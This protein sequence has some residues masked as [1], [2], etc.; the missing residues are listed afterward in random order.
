MLHVEH[1]ML[2]TYPDQAKS[3]GKIVRNP[4]ISALKR[5]S[6]Q[7][8]ASVDDI[9]YS[10]PTRGKI[11]RP[12]AQLEESVARYIFKLDTAD[13]K[14]PSDV[15]VL[16]TTRL[17]RKLNKLKE[18]WLADR[19]VGFLVAVAGKPA[20]GHHP[21]VRPRSAIRVAGMSAGDCMAAV[22]A[23]IAAVCCL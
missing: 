4:L 22:C 13:R 17:K 7:K 6:R 2:Y 5:I 20:P 10:A 1:V 16:K 18:K 9:Q 11:D 19:D 15:L 14:E 21:D 3:N 12:R 8:L 23:R